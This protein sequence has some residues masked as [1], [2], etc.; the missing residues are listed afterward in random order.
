[1]CSGLM[2]ELITSNQYKVEHVHREEGHFDRL[3]DLCRH[4]QVSCCPQLLKIKGRMPKHGEE[5]TT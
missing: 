2:E 1:M 3:S 5:E 4:H